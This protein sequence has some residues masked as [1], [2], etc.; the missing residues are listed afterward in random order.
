MKKII[1]TLEEDGSI[2][3]QVT[4]PINF[5]EIVRISAALMAKSVNIGLRAKIIRE[6][7]IEDFYRRT[8][9]A[10]RLMV[11]MQND[12]KQRPGEKRG[13]GHG[14]SKGRTE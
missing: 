3:L 13:I 4:G 8:I 14:R 11:K 5:Q 2:Y 12:E 10:A 1:L 6:D 9:G 7:E